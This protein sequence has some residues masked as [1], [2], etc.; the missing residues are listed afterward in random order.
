VDVERR[1]GLGA[2]FQSGQVFDQDPG[3]GSVRPHGSTVII[4]AYE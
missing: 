4:Y 1:G 2:I 3:P